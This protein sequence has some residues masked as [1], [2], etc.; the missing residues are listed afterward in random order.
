MMLVFTAC[1]RSAQTADDRTARRYEVRGIIRGFAPDRRTIDIEHETIPGFMPSM[2]MPFSVRNPKEIAEFRTGEAISFRLI[3]TDNDSWIDQIKKISA[4]EVRLPASTATPSA[5][6]AAR[7]SPRLREG[8]MMP[9]FQLTNQGG[10]PITLETFRGRPFVVTFIFT[11]CPIPNYCPLMSKNFATLQEAI[12]TG[13]GPVAQ[14]RLLS[15]SFDPEFDSS[16]VL[17]KY[18]E[19]EQADATVWTFATGTKAEIDK[20]TRAFS[21]YVQPEAGT[22]SHGLATALIDQ[23]GRIRKLWRGNAWKPDEVSAAVESL[24]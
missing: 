2:T 24:Q 17:K 9:P 14:T 13:S 12:K 16:Q 5:S 20:L 3:V 11:R 1:E 19:N 8:D 4:E 21:V 22:L 7:A 6:P 10:E 18:A 23:D 15:I